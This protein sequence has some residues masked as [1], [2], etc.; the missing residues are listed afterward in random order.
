VKEIFYVCV[1]NV[2][3]SVTKKHQLSTFENLI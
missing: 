1:C 2:S 3:F